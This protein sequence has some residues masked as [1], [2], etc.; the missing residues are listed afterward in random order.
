MPAHS[1][2][3]RGFS[4]MK[5]QILCN[6]T[7]S[8]QKC[9]GL[10][11]HRSGKREMLFWFYMTNFEVWIISWSINLLFLKSVMLATS[12][13][14]TLMLIIRVPPNYIR[15]NQSLI[16]NTDTVVKWVI[17]LEPMWYYYFW[18]FWNAPEFGHQVPHQE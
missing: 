18:L 4:L 11:R 3:I 17:A 14:F 6:F 2:E 12:G 7:F 1:S 15:I 10:C 9:S 8:P 13:K 16:C 5:W